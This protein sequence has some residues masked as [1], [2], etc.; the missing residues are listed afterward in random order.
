MNLMAETLMR[1]VSPVAG[2]DAGRS[3]AFAWLKQHLYEYS[4]TDTDSQGTRVSG[5]KFTECEYLGM[6]ANNDMARIICLACDTDRWSEPNFGSLLDLLTKDL[7]DVLEMQLVKIVKIHDEAPAFQD[8]LH[9]LYTAYELGVSVTNFCSYLSSAKNVY[10]T[11]RDAN[12]SI[13]EIAK[14][15]VEVVMGKATS[16]KRKLDEGGWIDRIM[17]NVSQSEPESF[18]DSPS[19]GSILMEIVTENFLEQWAG[20]V[21]ES[22]R[23]SA[24]GFSYF[25][26]STEA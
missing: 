10:E 9:S 8:T 2:D 6:R 13:D 12:L 17:E 20:N 14:R 24:V 26:A 16:I 7:L 21:L 19:I 22:W 15:L 1:V 18:Q 5:H 11:Q 25:K 23:D 4:E 3:R